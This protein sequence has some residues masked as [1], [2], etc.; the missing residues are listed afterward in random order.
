MHYYAS[1]PRYGYEDGCRCEPDEPSMPEPE[2]ELDAPLLE[3]DPFEDDPVQPLSPPVALEA[4]G[5]GVYPIRVV[6]AVIYTRS[7]SPLE[8]NSPARFRPDN[9]MPIVREARPTRCILDVEEINSSPTR[10]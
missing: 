2:E 7:A 6:S 1:K 8:V 3:G 9:A 4:R 10:R 5:G